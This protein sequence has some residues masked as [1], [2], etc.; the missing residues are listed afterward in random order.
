MT[1]SIITTKLVRLDEDFGASSSEVINQLAEVVTS[2]GRASDSQQLATDALD[3]ESKAPTGV[4]GRVAI[5]HC[6]SEAVSVPTLAFA[7][8]S[9]PVDFGGPDGD[10]DLIFLIAA[11]A[12]GGKEHL[13]IL[14]KLARALVREDFLTQLR[15]ATT[16]QDIVDAVIEVVTAEKKKKPAQ[17]NTPDEGLAADVEKRKIHLVAIT[18]CPTGIAH[19][20][21]AADALAQ[22]A[23]GRDDI[24][25]AVE[26]QGSSATK[27]LAPDV[28]A[29]ADAVIFA[30]DVGVR[31]RERFAGKP[32]IESGV[33]RAI[34]EPTIMLDEAIAASQNPNARKVSGTASATATSG[35]EGSQLGWGRR[36]QQAV[37]TGVSY[38]IP[39]V[40]AGGLLMALGFLIGGYDVANGW[41]AI[42]TGFSPTN[43][44]GNMIEID[45]AMVAFER[46]GIAL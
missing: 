14:S 7:R 15:E 36:I 34:N 16:S 25:L 20:Y 27:G 22:A 18:A 41:Q 43:L 13:K 32:V 9:Q 12:G 35:D 23:E 39:F 42:A 45:G 26:T 29:H 10:A 5:P 3:R 24:E 37:M 30:T 4:P 6:R 8:L 1:T 21:M 31:D 28:I 44:P 11:P 40:A 33:K 46:S 38:M 19:T 17:E 2:A